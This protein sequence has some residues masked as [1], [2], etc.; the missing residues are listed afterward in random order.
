MNSPRVEKAIAD[1]EACNDLDSLRNTIH[2]IA[3]D[4][5]FS[6]CAFVDAGD[7][8]SREPFYFSTTDPQWDVEYA[9]NEFVKFDPC[10]AR[11]RRSNIP[12]VWGDV[13]VAE[14]RRGPKSGRQ[15]LMEAATDFGFTEGLVV[16]CHFRDQLGNFQSASSVFFWKD[17]A[18]R[19]NFLLS[20]QKIALHLL[21]IY[22]IQKFISIRNQNN[23]AGQKRHGMVL[24]G[25]NR[26]LSDRERDVL[27]WA[28]RGKTSSEIAEILSLAVETVDRHFKNAI[29][30]LN[31]ATRTQAVAKALVQGII[32]I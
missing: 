6:S 25:G 2:R 14:A 9:D 21:M 22:F 8:H 19:F 17:S 10:V 28:A 20:D 16:P 29:R 4:Y 27:C 18:S 31:A 5:G 24:L 30:K 13:I 32:D 12:F 11:A 23:L 26:D 1:I 7:T 3:Q 15:R